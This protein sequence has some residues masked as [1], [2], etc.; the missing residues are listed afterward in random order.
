MLSSIEDIY[1]KERASDLRDVGK[2]V[3]GI[4]MKRQ[5][6]GA[7]ELEEGAVVV[8]DEL[9]PSTT[10]HMELQKVAGFVTER[11][12]R[13][14]HMA[15]LARSLG[16]P[17]VV[18]VAEATL[19][20]RDGDQIVI[21][22]ITGAV[23]VNPKKNIVDE[24]KKLKK[25]LGAARRALVALAELPCLT[26][27]GAKIS[28]GANIGKRADAEAACLFNADGIGLYRTEFSY[29]IRDTLPSEEDQYQIYRKVV[30]RLLPKEVVI[31]VLDLGSDKALAY[32]PVLKEEN[33]SLGLR[34]IRFL[35]KYRDIFRTELNAILRVNALYPVSLLFPM[36]SEVDEIIQAKA[37]LE[38]A[39]AALKKKGMVFEKPLKIGAMIEVPSAV[40]QIER[41]AREV[42]F[43]S[44]GTNDLIQYTM[45]ADRLS[46]DVENYYEELHPSLLKMILAVVDSGAA[47]NKEVSIC[48]EMAGDSKLTKLLLGMGLRKFSVPPGELLEVKKAI[49][50]AD[51]PGAKAF[52][53]KILKLETAGEV[54]ACFTR[55]IRKAA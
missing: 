45:A 29:L 8:A 6:A 14:S 39:R 11:G 41:I 2:R 25:T 21:D 22:G 53:S 26:K 31:R 15:I 27:D 24:Y 17:A 44:I 20:I 4:L 1:L 42:D 43:L 32:F 52:A 33:P 28:L 13:N 54:K 16:I 47:Q 36:I 50:A 38:Q 18:D 34:G 48:G 46:Q 35:M 5:P 30:E 12:S 51:L 7:L 55:K 23:F 3:L 10:I 40:L 49:M 9:S 37:M 19:K